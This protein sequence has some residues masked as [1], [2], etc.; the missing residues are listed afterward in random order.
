MDISVQCI[1]FPK[2]TFYFLLAIF[3][4]LVNTRIKK[5][6]I[7]PCSNVGLLSMSFAPRVCM[8]LRDLV[9]WPYSIC[10]VYLKCS[11]ETITIWKFEK[12][13]VTSLEWPKLLQEVGLSSLHQRGAVV[14]LVLSTWFPFL[15]DWSSED[16]PSGPKP[17]ESQDILIIILCFV[18][19][20]YLI[21]GRNGGRL[22]IAVGW[23]QAGLQLG[24]FGP[25]REE[26]GTQ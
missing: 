5:P 11:L 8:L 12:V 13:L 10:L 21:F 3:G 9:D 16:S 25:I 6:Q 20:A 24:C 23:S 15:W 2:H 22:G 4:S 18:I 26:N 7:T 17:I 1:R 14:F 19:L